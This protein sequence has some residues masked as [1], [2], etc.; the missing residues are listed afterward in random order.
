[1]TEARP[2]L[3]ADAADPPP[4]EAF[5]LIGTTRK[6]N[7]MARSAKNGA[8]EAREIPAPDFKRAI[9]ILKADLN[10]LTEESAKVRGDQAAAW[11]MIEKDCNC[12]KKALKAVHALMRMAPELRDDYLRSL[13]GG[14]QEAGI[15][16]SE[17]MVDRM[18][19]NEAPTMPTT[20]RGS[21]ELVTVQ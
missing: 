21:V 16:I 17:D 13:Y 9:K 10:P 6:D 2:Y 8:D 5:D 20:K 18:E 11:K 14:M 4:P 12:N 3:E 7:A 1:M 15:G 19:G